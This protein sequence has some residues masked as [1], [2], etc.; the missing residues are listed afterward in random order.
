M[1]GSL[2]K[3]EA[4]NQ[5]LKTIYIFKMSLNSEEAVVRNSE[6][7]WALVRT[8]ARLKTSP[9]SKYSVWEEIKCSP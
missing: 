9:D 1:T 4:C 2:K 5:K 6:M 3:K 7:K 8:H